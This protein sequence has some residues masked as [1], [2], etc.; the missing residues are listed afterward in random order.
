[1]GSIRQVGSKVRVSCDAEHE[2]KSA[3]AFITETHEVDRLSLGK[4]SYGVFSLQ[5]QIDC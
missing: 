2:T 5:G 4:L 1:M 3:I